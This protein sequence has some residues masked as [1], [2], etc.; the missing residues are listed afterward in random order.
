MKDLRLKCNITSL[1]CSPNSSMSS[2]RL[3]PSARMLHYLNQIEAINLD[4][5]LFNQCSF[6]V[7]QL[8][9][10]AGLSCASSILEVFPKAKHVLVVSGPG[11][12]GG[13]GLVCA[14]H[15]KIFGYQPEVYY[16][17]P[18]SNTLYRN[19]IEQ[20]KHF[21]IP[22][23]TSCP[24]LEDLNLKYSLVI[25]ALFGFSFK[26]PV[27]QE[28]QEIMQKLYQTST[29]CCSIDIPS[30]WDVETG[31]CGKEYLKPEML[32]SLTA[33]KICAKYFQGKYHY[34][35]GRF[36][37]PAIAIKY[38][39]TYMSRYTSSFSYLNVGDIQDLNSG[40]Q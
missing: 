24:P 30:G 6:S 19:L 13:D 37:P 16:P 21:E 1:I 11:N 4:K 18:T 34:L 5:D 26:P 12:N 35:A 17:K 8:M 40:V 36:I 3:I 32:I 20:C 28:F 22:I 7:E 15:L 23:I 29:P 33:P 2:P 25:D 14:R 38:K 27:R 31:P 39:L 10:L 9:E